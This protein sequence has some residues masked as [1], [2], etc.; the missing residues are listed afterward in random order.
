MNFPPER[1]AQQRLVVCVCWWY[2]IEYCLLQPILLLTYFEQCRAK[3]SLLDSI[4]PKRQLP[5]LF[6]ACCSV[7]ITNTTTGSL[8]NFGPVLSQPLA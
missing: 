5:S 8:E 7:L 6:L 1:R 4:N 2:V 3:L